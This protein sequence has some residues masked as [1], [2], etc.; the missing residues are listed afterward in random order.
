MASLGMHL[1]LPTEIVAR[2][3]VERGHPMQR[4]LNMKLPRLTHDTRRQSV[5]GREGDGNGLAPSGYCGTSWHEPLVR[6]RWGRANF[7]DACRTHDGCY[8]TCGMWREEC[9]GHFERDMESECRRAY[10]GGGLDA[11]KRASCIG[12]ANTYAVAVERLG[13]DAYKAAQRESGCG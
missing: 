5:F 2:D 7:S 13:G 9:D 3:G 11:I 12:I 10:P 6:D 8:E 1:Q 4:G